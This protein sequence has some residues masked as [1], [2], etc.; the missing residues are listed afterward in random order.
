MKKFKALVQ[1]ELYHLFHSPVAWIFA[2]LFLLLNNFFYFNNVFL[3]GQ[4]TMRPYFTNL[5]LILLFFVAAAEMSAFSEEKKSK[6]L[7][8]LLSLPVKKWQIAISKLLSFIIFFT[9][10][11]FFTLSIPVTLFLIGNPDIGPIISGYLGTLLLAGFYASV[12]IYISTFFKEQ[13]ITALITGLVL[14]TLHILGQNFILERVSFQLQYILSFI[15]PNTHF[16]NFAK[17]VIDIG[18]LVYFLSAKAILVWLTIKNI[19]FNK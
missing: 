2:V 19:G 9:A 11:L 15:S 18:D 4:A 10:V 1:K 7:E 17:G 6:T 16:L 14:F 8:I 13:V 5:S 3:I 12:G